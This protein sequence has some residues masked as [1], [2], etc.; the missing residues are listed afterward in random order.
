MIRVC[1]YT[2]LLSVKQSRADVVLPG[3][4]DLDSFPV[5]MLASSNVAFTSGLI[6]LLQLQSS[7]S[8]S[9]KRQKKEKN[10]LEISGSLIP[11]F[12]LNSV[13]LCSVIQRKLENLILI[14]DSHVL[15]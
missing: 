6:G 7:Q 15:R 4:Q 11:H 8:P 9:R 3:V 12:H 10:I 2:T 1:F 13:S 14:S 5:I